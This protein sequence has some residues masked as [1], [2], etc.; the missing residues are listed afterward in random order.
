MANYR[1]ST[2]SIEEAQ[3]RAAQY[4]ATRRGA[5]FAK[6]LQTAWAG[7]DT[8]GVNDLQYCKDLIEAGASF[9]DVLPNLYAVGYERGLKAGRGK[10]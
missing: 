9:A 7:L 4:E 3:E 5:T 2:S 6:K 8:L 1:V 10:A